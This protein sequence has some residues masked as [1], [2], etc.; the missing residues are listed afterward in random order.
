MAMLSK[1][2]I[3]MLIDAM[4]N[5]RTE[6]IE[7]IKGGYCDTPKKMMHFTD[8]LN[9]MT[10]IRKKLMAIKKEG[11]YDEKNYNKNRAYV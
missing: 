6:C 5:L 1:K 10:E 9:M 8:E 11:K 7:S 3:N 2:E 4:D